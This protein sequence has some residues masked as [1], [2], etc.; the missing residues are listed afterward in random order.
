LCSAESD[1]E[2]QYDSS[3]DNKTT[4]DD[5]RCLKVSAKAALAGITYD[6]GP[7]GVTKARIG[8]MENYTRYFPKGYGHAPGAK[9]VSKPC[10]NEVVGFKDF[11]YSLAPHA[12][13]SGTCGYSTQIFSSIAS[14]D[15]KCN[16]PDW[17]VYLGGHFLWGS[18]TADVFAQ[19]YELHYQ[20]KNIH[21]E[22]CETTLIVQFGCI[23]FHPSR[24][25]GRARLTPAARNKWMSGWASN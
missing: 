10:A 5:S 20:Y 16:C 23:T 14:V 17:Q 3:K 4:S 15:T 18:P 21:L 1:C 11:F 24:Y 9:L 8:S 25:G 7:S 22:G 6:F 2:S 13:P 19:Y 12:A